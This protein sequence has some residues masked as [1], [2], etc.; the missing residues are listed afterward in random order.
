MIRI[1]PAMACVALAFSCSKEP[2]EA[3]PRTDS[4]VL[5]IKV[6]GMQRGAGTYGLRRRA[7]RDIYARTYAGRVVDGLSP[8]GARREASADAVERLGDGRVRT[9][10][11]ACYLDPAA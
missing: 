4:P 3:S 1:V 5:A 7:A 2:D 6:D 8:R 11:A 9:D 10:V